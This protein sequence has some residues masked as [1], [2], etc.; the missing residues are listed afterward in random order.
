M[1]MTQKRELPPE[2]RA[3]LLAARRAKDESDEAF[4]RLVIELGEAV[5]VNAVCRAA[6]VSTSRYHDWKQKYAST[7]PTP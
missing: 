7:P 3:R 4:K 6:E 5:G 1:A 2:D